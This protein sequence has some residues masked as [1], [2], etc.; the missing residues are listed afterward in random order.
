[1][2]SD[3]TCRKRFLFLSSGLLIS[4]LKINSTAKK[5]R[6]EAKSVL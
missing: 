5:E 2:F 6:K 4:M 1:M 3:K